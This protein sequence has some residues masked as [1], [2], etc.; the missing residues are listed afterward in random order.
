LPPVLP[1]PAHLGRWSAVDGGHIPFVMALAGGRRRVV[2]PFDLLGAQ[3]DAVGGCVLPLGPEPAPSPAYAQE[4]A[5]PIVLRLE[6]PGRITKGLLRLPTPA[7]SP[8][9]SAQGYGVYASTAPVTVPLTSVPP[10]TKKRPPD[11]TPAPSYLAVGMDA[12]GA[13][14]LV[15]PV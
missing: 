9:D 10:I 11:A 3:L 6:E 13:Q 2:Q 14:L 1:T 4:P 7:L 5:D 15:E 8:A 12:W